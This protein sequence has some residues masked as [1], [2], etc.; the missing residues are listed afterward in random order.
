MID[1]LRYE[2][3]IRNTDP[4]QSHHRRTRFLQGWKNAEN[5]QEYVNDTLDSLTWENL[6]YRLGVLFGTTDEA[7][8]ISMYDWCVRQQAARNAE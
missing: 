1:G 4:N 5:E 2:E 7:E 6:G 3:D 8:K